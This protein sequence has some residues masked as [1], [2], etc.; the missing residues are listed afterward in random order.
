LPYP[1]EYAPYTADHVI[2]QLQ[3]LLFVGLAFGLLL[4]IGWHPLPGRWTHLDFD[5]LYRGVCRWLQR[6]SGRSLDEINRKSDVTVKRAAGGLAAFTDQG[7]ARIIWWL[8]GPF[9][10]LRGLSDQFLK[11]R[12]EK[13]NLTLGQGYPPVGLAA[14]AAA[15]MLLLVYLAL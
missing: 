10:R 14:G 8:M 4:K 2:G 5:W 6:A 3:L 11:L 12:R 9:Y 7:P 1:A 13:L 15:V